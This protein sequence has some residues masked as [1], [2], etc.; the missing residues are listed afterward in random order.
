MPA[1]R[2]RIAAPIAVR[3][4]AVVDEPG[5]EIVVSIGKPTPDPDGDWMCPFLVEGLDGARRQA[6]RGLDAL[7][8]L[9][10]AVEGARV[11]LAGSGLR[12]AWQGGE[13]GDTGIP[14]AVPLFYGLRFAEQIER[15][16]D[17]AIQRH[18]PDPEAE[19]GH[20]PA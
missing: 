11:T 3:R 8:A 19:R 9:L 10:M 14:R 7:Q 6:A 17:Q 13:P 2:P 16:L 20:K 1:K 12:L 5:R 18:A 15:H 4:L